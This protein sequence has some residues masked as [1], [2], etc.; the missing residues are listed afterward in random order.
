[1]LSTAIAIP[2]IHIRY[3]DRLSV[4]ELV[5]EDPRYGIDG[6]FSVREAGSPLTHV[7]VVHRLVLLGVQANI[8]GLRIE[9]LLDLV[10]H[11]VVHRLHVEPGSESF[12]DA[13]DDRQLSRAFVRFLE[14]PL[15]LIEQSR[16]LERHAQTARERREQSDV[17]F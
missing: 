8:D 2:R 7:D 15:R 11:Q 13:V 14:Q 9:D 5:E 6:K 3:E 4:G 17:A 16:T 1:M 10:A 12:L